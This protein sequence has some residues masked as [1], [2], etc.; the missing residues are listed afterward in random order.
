MNITKIISTALKDARRLVKFYRFGT[1]DVRENY[2]ASPFGLDSNPV[3][4]T[5]GVFSSTTSNGQGVILGYVHANKKA[6]VGEFRTYATDANGA[7]VFYT[8]IKADGTME[9]GGDT[10]NMVRFSELKTA[11]DQLKSDFDSLVS[12]YNTHIHT[13]T[14]T[15]GPSPTIFGVISPTTSTGSPTTANIDPSKIDEIKTI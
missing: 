13:T 8:W 7:E 14:A 15:V 9:I 1:S 4:D 3:K 5:V 6:D 10:D 2:E 11:F 12:S